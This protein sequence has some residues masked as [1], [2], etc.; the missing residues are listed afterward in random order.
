MQVLQLDVS[1]SESQESES[2][3][4]TDGDVDKDKQKKE[5]K[6][7]KWQR[8][9]GETF[10][11]QNEFTNDSSV[12]GLYQVSFTY[13]FLAGKREIYFAHSLPYTYSMLNEYLSKQKVKR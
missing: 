8:C 5:P 9:P 2:T 1:K 7:P 11:I 6:L 3:Q 13:D 10:Y 12:N 4:H